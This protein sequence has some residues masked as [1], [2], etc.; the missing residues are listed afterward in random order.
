MSF[1]SHWGSAVRHLYG[2]L[3]ATRRVAQ[4]DCR[5]SVSAFRFWRFC[6]SFFIG[7]DCLDDFL[8]RVV[9]LWRFPIFASCRSVSYGDLA[10]PINLEAGP[11][12]GVQLNSSPQESP[13]IPNRYSGLRIFTSVSSVQHRANEPLNQYPTAIAE[14]VCC[15]LV[16]NGSQ[17][18]VFLGAMFCSELPTRMRTR[19]DDRT[20]PFIETSAVENRGGH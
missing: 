4:L 6:W 10:T 14:P 17:R 15:S 3:R 8:H 19:S 9:S 16:L 5:V 18:L 7:T 13:S 12:R 1:S 20:T 11:A 2:V